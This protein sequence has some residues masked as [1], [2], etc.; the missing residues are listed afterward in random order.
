MARQDP[1]LLAALATSG[2]LFLTL[3]LAPS[4]PWRIPLAL[5]GGIWA[6][7]YALLAV[8]YPR[9]RLVALERH[10]LAAAAGLCLLPVLTL[11]ASET[12]RLTSARV[13]GVGL[14]LTLA[15]A[16]IALRKPT[17]PTEP[18][19]R[20]ALPSTRVTVA[21]CALALLLAAVVEAR[22]L[23]SAT[24]EPASL[25]MT[26]DAG[27]PLELQ[28]AQGAPAAVLVSPR[29]GARAVTDTL[30]VTW[31]GVALDARDVS[32]SP[33]EAASIVVPLPTDAVG[34]HAL[35]ATWAGRETHATFQV[36]APDA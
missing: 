1:A 28:V 19:V 13:A 32:L 24:E 10:A 15:L 33:G 25:A 29:A 18:V 35:V 8:A 21:M 34:A 36:V 9:G 30:S 20:G 31:D 11:V 12:V 3:L 22:S 26:S 17:T 27:G 16:A 4:A 23:S 7:G 6:P 5:L 2:A 14:V